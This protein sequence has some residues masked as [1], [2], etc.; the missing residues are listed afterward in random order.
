MVSLAVLLEGSLAR[1]HNGRAQISESDDVNSHV[2]SS[3]S[4]ATPPEPLDLAKDPRSAEPQATQSIN[5]VQLITL[6]FNATSPRSYI[7]E[8]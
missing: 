1:N 8:L 5:V 4:P 3:S 7:G 6:I 2:S